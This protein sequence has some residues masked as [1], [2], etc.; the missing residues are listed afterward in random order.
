MW[1]NSR[2]VAIKKFLA[3][4]CSECCTNNSALAYVLE[5][6]HKTLWVQAI[7][8]W[9]TRD[10]QAYVRD[11]R[12]IVQPIMQSPWALVLDARQWQTSPKEIFSGVT[13]NSIWCVQHQLA[14]VIALLPA[15]HVTGWQFLKAT[16]IDMP[17]SLVRQ[18]VDSTE[19]ARHNL[20]VAGYLQPEKI[21]AV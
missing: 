15:N 10:I 19:Q 3:G 12:A 13:D 17:E 1:L 2:C 21:G 7:G 11:F 16:A 4:M 6:E 5:L 18:R 9:T 14:H 20:V 8:V